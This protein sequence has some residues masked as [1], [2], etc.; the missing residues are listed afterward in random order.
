MKT[1]LF[2]I[3]MLL[4]QLTFLNAQD[5]HMP[6]ST[7]S[8]TAKRAYQAASYLGS[9]IHFDAAR[10]EIKKAIKA[11]PDFFMAYVYNYQV[12]ARG[13]AKA[14]VLDKALAIDPS[15]FTKAEKIMRKQLK[16][17]KADPKA[18]TAKTM[19]ALV[20]AHPNTPE[21]Y[22]WA[23]LHA[24]Y[25]DG[26]KESALKYAQKLIAIDPDFGPVYNGLGYL[27]MGK[28]EMDKAKTAFEKYLELAPAEAN[29]HDSM[30]DYYGNIGDHGK[31]AEYYEQAAA[32][33]MKGAKKRAEEA[34]AKKGN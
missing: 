31:S 10:L 30:G 28:K 29:A 6:V 32:L 19:K 25:T 3:V 9:N 13:G 18:K 21:A 16:A 22:E 2:S 1:L 4:G 20:A 5:F 12:L 8:E 15:D 14:A 23:Y 17:W 24:L 7:N 33:G 34:R 11:D 26:D 27:Y